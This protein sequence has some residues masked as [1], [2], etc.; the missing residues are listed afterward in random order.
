M[1]ERRS[2]DVGHD[3][4]LG[5]SQGVLCFLGKREL[6][7]PRRAGV[8]RVGVVVVEAANGGVFGERRKRHWVR[9]GIR[10]LELDP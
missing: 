5:F 8:A 6:L 7:E 2:L 4:E 10:W 9:T 1:G 3:H